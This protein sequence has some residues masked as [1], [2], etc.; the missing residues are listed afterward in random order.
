MKQKFA[1]L[2]ALV[3]LAMSQ[4]LTLI[5]ASESSDL[6]SSTGNNSQDESPSKEKGSRQNPIPLGE[7][8]DY[9]KKSRDGSKSQLSF[10]ILESW[11]GEK[12]EH[13][14]QQ[15]HPTSPTVSLWMTTKR[16]SY[17]I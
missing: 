12:A 16:F 6:A 17:C 2:V 8:L 10:T 3:A 9:E 14:L 1:I 11:R 15:L 5:Q 4:P 7:A 13:Q